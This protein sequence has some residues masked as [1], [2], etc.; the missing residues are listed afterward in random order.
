MNAIMMSPDNA[1]AISLG[2]KTQTRRTSKLSKVNHNPDAYILEDVIE[3]PPH[4]FGEFG[5]YAYFHREAKPHIQHVIKAPYDIDQYIFVRENWYL[6][7]SMPYRREEA[8]KEVSFKVKYAGEPNQPEH[9]IWMKESRYR[10]LSVMHT[11]GWKPS[12]FMPEEAA[13]LFVHITDLDV[14]RLSD[15]SNEDIL[16]EGFSTHGENSYVYIESGNKIFFATPLQGWKWLWESVNGPGSYDK[17][18][19]IWKICF[20]IAPKPIL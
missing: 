10:E 12:L 20:E 13:R 19:W 9:E 18:P 3:D 4:L 17:N 16:A 15:V 2:R 5:T 11:K 8:L 6:V 7:D 1:H 14:Q